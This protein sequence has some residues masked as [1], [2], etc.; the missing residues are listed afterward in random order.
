MAATL[1]PT[2]M[3]S[4]T[5]SKSNNTLISPIEGGWSFTAYSNKESFARAMVSGFA[6]AMS[7]A[8]MDD[9]GVYPGTARN[10][11][12][13]YWDESDN[14]YIETSHIAFL[15][16]HG[17]VYGGPDL[18]YEPAALAKASY[19]FR[20]G[21]LGRLQWVMIAA[22][23]VLGY[24]RRTDGS[25]ADAYPSASRW[26]QAFRGISGIVGYRSYSWYR[27]NEPGLGSFM[28]G[29]VVRELQA[30]QSFWRAWCAGADWLHSVINNQADAAV[31]ANSLEALSD[32]LV[33][34]ASERREGLALASVRNRIVGRGDTPTYGYT[35]TVTG[36]DEGSDG[37]VPAL[38]SVL[39]SVGERI[40]AAP[41]VWLTQTMAER[42]EILPLSIDDLEVRLNVLHVEKLYDLVAD[43][44]RHLSVF[45]RPEALSPQDVKDLVELIIGKPPYKN[46]LLQYSSQRTGDIHVAT[47]AA[48]VVSSGRELPILDFGIAVEHDGKRSIVRI[49][50]LPQLGSTRRVEKLS[51][52]ADRARTVFESMTDDGTK[53]EITSSKL[54]YTPELENSTLVLK[55]VI[56]VSFVTTKGDMRQSGQIL[57]S[58]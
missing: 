10:H 7:A 41:D 9:M 47:V 22:C 3:E 51:F 35:E 4:F 57:L 26:N 16:C 1:A 49:G 56:A 38:N 34:F 45:A 27:A 44:G 46:L 20:W 14:D 29:V 54:A 53:V 33:S 21:D 36:A 42:L 37:V 48:S 6:S 40:Y 18:E 8:K 12:I 52:D 5:L 30:G 23:D 58:E 39:V 25:I 31:F 50:S 24:T 2:G 11:M 15:D 28:A 17:N 19:R 32:T 55:P 43:T 13:E